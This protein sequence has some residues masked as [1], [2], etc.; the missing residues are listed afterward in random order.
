M[1][2]PQSPE[3]ERSLDPPIDTNANHICGREQYGM[4]LQLESTSSSWLLD[5]MGSG[6]INQLARTQSCFSGASDFSPSS[7]F[8]NLN[9]NGQHYQPILYQQ[10]RR[11][12]L[13]GIIGTSNRSLEL[14]ST[15]QDSDSGTT[16]QRSEQHDSRYGIT[17]DLLQESVENQ[18]LNIPTNIAPLGT[19]LGR[20]LR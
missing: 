17:Q 18:A 3:V 7:A 9:S 16:H 5:S 19:L 12:S 2:V 14:V 15:A 13:S 6:T 11:D 8:H 20:P 10:T 1:V 4:G